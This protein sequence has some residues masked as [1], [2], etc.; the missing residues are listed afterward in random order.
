MLLLNDQ[1]SFMRF[2]QPKLV[3]QHEGNNFTKLLILDWR[4]V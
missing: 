1:Q 2:Q 4:L 3:N